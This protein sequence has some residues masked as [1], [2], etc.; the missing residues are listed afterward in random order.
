MAPWPARAEAGHETTYYANDSSC[1]AKDPEHA[2]GG[3]V[4]LPEHESPD[5]TPGD[6]PTRGRALLDDNSVVGPYQTV[7]Q[8]GEHPAC[9][10][11]PSQEFLK[12]FKKGNFQHVSLSPT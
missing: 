5:A 9:P 11:D 1:L 10:V 6:D 8:V 7:D 4:I 2:P 12:S 3:N